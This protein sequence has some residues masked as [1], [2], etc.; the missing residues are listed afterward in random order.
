[1]SRKS[2]LGSAI[3]IEDALSIMVVVFVLFIV[4]FLPMVSIDQMK[5]EKAQKDD[6][7]PGIK[8][9]ITT[10][11]IKGNPAP[12][13]QTF[14][15]DAERTIVEKDS[16][17]RVNYIESV[18][19]EDNLM[20]VEHNLKDDTFVL[21]FVPQFNKAVTYVHGNLHWSDPESSWFK[22]NAIIDYEENEKSKKMQQKYRNWVQ[23][24]EK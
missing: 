14:N 6:F 16:L 24:Y 21:L 12:Y 18:D 4:F 2:D 19:S 9:R 5:L 17:N 15:L 20:I 8:E 11:E 3:S 23:N 7:W 10:Q 22:S 1:M 13:L